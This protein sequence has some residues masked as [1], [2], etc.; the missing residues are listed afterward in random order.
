MRRQIHVEDMIKWMMLL[1]IISP[2]I[3]TPN[4][5]AQTGIPASKSLWIRQKRFSA[6]FYCSYFN[7]RQYQ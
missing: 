7:A 5:E 6:G 2:L 3:W 4:L 1:C